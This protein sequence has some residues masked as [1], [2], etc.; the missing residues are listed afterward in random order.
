MPPKW[1]LLKVTSANR[2]LLLP[3]TLNQIIIELGEPLICPFTLARACKTF[4]R[5]FQNHQ[6]LSSHLHLEKEKPPGRRD[7]HSFW[8]QRIQFFSPNPLFFLN[9]LWVDINP[10]PQIPH[11]VVIIIL[12]SHMEKQ[13]F[14]EVKLPAPLAAQA[15]KN[16]HAMGQTQVRSLGRGDLL[17][18]G[19]AT[20]PVFLPPVDR[21]AW[22]AR[23]HGVSKSQTQLSRLTF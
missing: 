11:K 22:R 18:K 13:M 6:V 12:I 5:L 8:G 19:M 20:H 2:H 23:V 15:V 16:Q 10:S 1:S 3:F 7:I 9:N 21:R 17:K 14:E 4:C